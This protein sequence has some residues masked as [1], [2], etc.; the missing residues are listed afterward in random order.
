MQPGLLAPQSFNLGGTQYVVAQFSDGTYV[1]PPGA[2]AGITSRRARPGDTITIYGVGFGPV[3]TFTPRG[4]IAQGQS[5][6]AAS[7]TMS[8]GGTQAAVAYDGL[9]PT[10]VG[11]YQFNVTV[12]AIAPSDTVP[13]TFTLGGIT[14][15]QKLFI[16]VG[17]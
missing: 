17:S 5:T 13:L 6:L 10:Y 2:I 12:Q 15:N 14:G 8:F 1:L 3:S 4:Q 7:F 16:A 11:L 9:A